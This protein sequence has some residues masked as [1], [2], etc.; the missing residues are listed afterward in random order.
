MIPVEKILNSFRTK[1]W[2]YETVEHVHPVTKQ[3]TGGPFLYYFNRCGPFFIISTGGGGPLLYYFNGW[4]P[5]FIISTGGA[6]SSLFQRVSSFFI[7]STGGAPSLS[8]QRVGPFLLFQRVHG[9]P[10]LLFQ[11]V[12]PLLYYFNGCIGPCSF[13]LTF[14]W[15]LIVINFRSNYSQI[16]HF[17]VWIFKIFVGLQR[18]PL[19]DLSSALSRASPS[20]RAL[21]SF[22]FQAP[23]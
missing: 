12:G 23:P 22:W 8:F 18:A 14:R 2:V 1:R 15:L 19:P 10:S 4:G 11:R 3:S 13:V 21:P 9:A 6:P 5:F 17:Q 16:V 20:V 7:I